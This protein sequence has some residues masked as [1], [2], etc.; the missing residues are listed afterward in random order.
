[1][2]EQAKSHLPFRHWTYDSTGA[3]RR[4]LLFLRYPV[5]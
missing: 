5:N 1:M 2:S 3:I 4:H